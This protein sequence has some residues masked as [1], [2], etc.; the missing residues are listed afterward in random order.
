LLGKLGSIGVVGKVAKWLACFL[1]DRTQCVVVNGARS[2]DAP[3]ISGVPQGTVLGPLL[4]LI[5][6]NDI[7]GRVQSARIASFADDTRI[8][9]SVVTDQDKVRLQE[10][11]QIVY[12]WAGENNMVFNEDKF[13]LLHD[14]PMDRAAAYCGPGGAPIAVE[15]S[16]RDLGILMSSD[17][18]FREHVRGVASV[19]RRL[20]GYIL[21]TFNT[22]ESVVLGVLW[23]ALV[24]PRM[25][26]GSQLWFLSGKAGVREME[27]LQRTFTGDMAALRELNYWE[28]L[29]VLN[30]Y[31]VERR[32]ERYMVLYVWKILEG[33]LEPPHTYRIEAISNARRG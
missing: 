33:K 4:F 3:V 18:T 27:N 12:D 29:K 20:R 25:D 5:M 1:K 15:T 13:A 8:W 17:G 9:K 7:G 2:Q 26:Y 24:L 10:D 11:L 31:S 19:C 22:R 23:R 16:Y 14:G 32:F 6:V 21:R 28:R 30:L